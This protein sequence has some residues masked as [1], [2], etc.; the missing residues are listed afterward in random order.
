VVFL[1]SV[2]PVFFAGFFPVIIFLVAWVRRNTYWKITAFDVLCGI[3]SFIALVLWIVTHKTGISILFAILSDALA[4]VPTLIKAW[5]HPE[6]ETAIGYTPGLINNILAL[7][8]IRNWTFSLYSFSIYF[9]LLNITL[10][11]FIVR[12][13]IFPTKI[14]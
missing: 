10:I 13:K 5:K 3:F 1:G 8:L 4:A 14:A 7:L 11:V 12:K 2:I 6:T 9:I